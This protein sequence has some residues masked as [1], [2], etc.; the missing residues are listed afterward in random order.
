M[1]LPVRSSRV[2]E[3]LDVFKTVKCGGTIDGIQAMLER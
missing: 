3:L 1:L 2:V